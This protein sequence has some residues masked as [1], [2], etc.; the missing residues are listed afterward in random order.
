M[1]RPD[2]AHIR[3]WG[4]RSLRRVVGVAVG[5]S[6]ALAAGCASPPPPPPTMAEVLDGQATAQARSAA[7]AE[8]EQWPEV[9]KVRGFSEVARQVYTT[10]TEGKDGWWTHDGFRLKCE[11]QTLVYFGWNGEYIR[12]RDE[13]TAR[14]NKACLGSDFQY[15]DLLPDNTVGELG[16]LYTC[17][18]STKVLT[19]L[20][21]GHAPT[22]VVTMRSWGNTY[23]DLRWIAGTKD[24]ALH[25]KLMSA[26]WLFVTNARVVFYQ[27][28]VK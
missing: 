28:E 24:D 1:D 18:P 8:V 9:V 26:Q 19:R 3:A 27:D 5:L 6:L 20:A 11:A 12:G 2:V 25:K 16:P 22:V 23:G 7:L 17:P 4:L 15:S 10:C 13:V 14:L 21:N